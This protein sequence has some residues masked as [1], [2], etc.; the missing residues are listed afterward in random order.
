M[1]IAGKLT[2]LA[3][4]LT[5]PVSVTESEIREEIEFHL[6]MVTREYTARGMNAEDAR[7]KAEDQFGD[8]EQTFLDCRKNSLGVQMVLQRFQ[9]ALMSAMGVAI[10][11]LGVA[12]WQTNNQYQLQLS[13]MRAEL[14][15]RLSAD[16]LNARLPGDTQSL[17]DAIVLEIVDQFEPKTLSV[18]WADWS[19]LTDADGLGYFETN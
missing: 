12:L 16:L 3:Y 19:Q 10:V 1:G 9:V 13:T 17:K 7:R 2:G 14:E 15:S 4:D 11:W 5:T 18:P 6:E 8:V